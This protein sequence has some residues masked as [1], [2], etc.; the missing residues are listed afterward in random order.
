MYSAAVVGVRGVGSIRVDRLLLVQFFCEQLAVIK[1][2][3]RHQARRF[4]RPPAPDARLGVLV[5]VDPEVED[6]VAERRWTANQNPFFQE[7]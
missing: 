7:I 4:Q 1:L 5:M 6:G 3:T 2:Q